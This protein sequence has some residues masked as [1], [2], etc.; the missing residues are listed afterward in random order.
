MEAA[1]IEHGPKRSVNRGV[2]DQSGAESGALQGTSS[3][4]DRDLG[5]NLD[6][7]VSRLIG[8]WPRLSRA[9]KA[10]ILELAAA[11]IQDAEST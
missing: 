7:D 9:T 5:A 1:G 11:A 10:R 2:G 4:I 3:H 8:A 6:A